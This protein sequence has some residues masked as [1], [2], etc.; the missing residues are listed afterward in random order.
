MDIYTAEEKDR[1]L[2]AIVSV[3]YIS[4]DDKRA[5]SIIDEYL[6]PCGLVE[7]PLRLS[8]PDHYICMTTQ[9]GKDFLSAGGFSKMQEDEDKRNLLKL[10]QQELIRLQ[11][12]ELLYKKKIRFWQFVS[13]LFALLSAIL[14]MS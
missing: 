7:K 4:I 13:A 11:K 9:K 14:G 1:V 2:N 12:E 8:N 10:E 6:Y 5:M 3:D